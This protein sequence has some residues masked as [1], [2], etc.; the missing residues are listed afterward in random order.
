MKKN[1]LHLLIQIYKAFLSMKSSVDDHNINS[2][3]L[4]TLYFLLI[5]TINISRYLLQ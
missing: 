3:L 1:L 2:I 5:C 4:Q